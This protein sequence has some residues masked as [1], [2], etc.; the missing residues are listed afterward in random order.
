MVAFLSRVRAAFWY[1]TFFHVVTTSL[2][3]LYTR[4]PASINPDVVVGFSVSNIVFASYWIYTAAKCQASPVRGAQVVA[5]SLTIAASFFYIEY[6][7]RTRKKSRVNRNTAEN[8][9][10]V[11]LIVAI[12]LALYIGNNLRTKVPPRAV[13]VSA[14]PRAEY[15][16][17]APVTRPFIVP[18][19]I[20]P[21][22]RSEK[23][24]MSISFGKSVPVA[25]TAVPAADGNQSPETKYRM[26]TDYLHSERCPGCKRE[27]LH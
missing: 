16:E 9:A 23:K 27:H 17:R 25:P 18:V 1:S 21:K 19:S 11:V 6:Q 26:V 13:R 7:N 24:V 15:V 8:T 5:A 3:L 10:W 14:P 2:M 12:P 20:F 22:P 4:H